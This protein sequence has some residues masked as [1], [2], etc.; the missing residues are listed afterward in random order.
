MTESVSTMPPAE[1]AFF[2]RL[3]G[4]YAGFEHLFQH[5]PTDNETLCGLGERGTPMSNN[6]LAHIKAD[7][8]I[9]WDEH[10]AHLPEDIRF[11][12]FDDYVEEITAWVV[13]AGKALPFWQHCFG[14]QR[15]FRTMKGTEEHAKLWNQ[16]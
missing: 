7:A 4:R 11:P 1:I 9:I 16:L 8:V 5:E 2:Q 13:G 3:T 6:G 15:F 12:L 14:E 10:F